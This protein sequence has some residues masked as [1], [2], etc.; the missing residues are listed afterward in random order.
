MTQAE[1]AEKAETTQSAIAR[2]ESGR[3]Q[4]TLAFMRR[5]AEALGKQFEIRLVKLRG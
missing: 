4:P 5:V 1:I 2:F 3:T